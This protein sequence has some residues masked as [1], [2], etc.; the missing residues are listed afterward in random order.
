MER[1]HNSSA[2][3][4]KKK[5]ASETGA[6]F[7][8]IRNIFL[9]KHFYTFSEFSLLL[10]STLLLSS[11]TGISSSY[12]S[13]KADHFDRSVK[14]KSTHDGDT[15]KLKTGEKLRLIG[16]DTPELGYDKQKPQ[17]YSWEA[18]KQ[19]TKLLHQHNN[20]VKLRYDVQKKDKYHRL[21][22]HLYL[23]NGISIS[24]WLLEKGL[25]TALTVPP[26]TWNLYCYKAA[27]KRAQAAR[28]G[29]WSLP[30]YQPI[31]SS[32]L[33]YSQK[34]FRLVRGKVVRIGY[35]KKSVWLNLTGKMAL[36][37]DR[38]DLPYFQQMN[39]ETLI[40]R[41][42]ISRGWLYSYK[43]ETRMQIRHPAALEVIQD[44]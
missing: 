31:E 11:V 22:A 28:R 1:R 18:K 42:V 38:K 36:R 9:A 30:S 34:G 6:P 17:P 25:A 3:G 35:S 40:G 23:D 32:T 41:T 10:L 33:K 43:G 7:F 2:N 24:E 39:P 27:E 19:L 15:I 37:I 29:I 26:N 8:I 20:Q 13:C 21:L 16:I 12:A 4:I 44:I 14:I 5:G